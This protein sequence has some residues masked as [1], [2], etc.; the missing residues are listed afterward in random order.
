MFYKIIAQL[1]FVGDSNKLLLFFV[2]TFCLSFL[3]FLVLFDLGF[4]S[5]N[6]IFQVLTVVTFLSFLWSNKKLFS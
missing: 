2:L 5:F 4:M 3:Q 6:L 1:S